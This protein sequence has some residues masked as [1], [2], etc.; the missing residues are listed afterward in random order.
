MVVAVD[1]AVKIWTD[2]AK[3]SISFPVKSAAE[4]ASQLG[5]SK[6]RKD[7]IFTIVA[8]AVEKSH[9]AH[10]R[11]RTK[12]KPKGRAVKPVVKFRVAKAAK[13]AIYTAKK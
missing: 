11:F 1:I 8:K 5:V 13:E 4:M 10:V 3:V 12:G 9:S 7:R 6:T 2:M